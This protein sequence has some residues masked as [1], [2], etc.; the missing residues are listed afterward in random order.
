M[1]ISTLLQV[2]VA[3]T[4]LFVWLV[5]ARK[6]TPY[7][8]GNAQSLRQEFAVYGLPE[9]SLFVVGGLKIGAAVALLVGVGVQALVLPAA[10]L[11]CVLMIGAIA[12]HVK[13]ADPIKKA[14]PASALLFFCASI[15]LLN[16]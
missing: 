4:L 13:V 7:R 2:I 16:R 6:F 10:L 11:L 8:G 12:M 9:W 5:Q 15:A 1:T 14:L 3:F